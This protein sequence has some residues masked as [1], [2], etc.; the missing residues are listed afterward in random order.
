MCIYFVV[1]PTSKQVDPHPRWWLHTLFIIFIWSSWPYGRSVETQTWPLCRRLINSV[2]FDVNRA[3]YQVC[4][5]PDVNQCI[6]IKDN[7]PT[8]WLLDFGI[9]EDKITFTCT[10]MGCNYHRGKD[11]SWTYIILYIYDFFPC[12]NYYI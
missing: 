12:G 9:S 7:S 5:S 6:W 2:R 10:C 4:E 8:L 3:L 1:L 11:R